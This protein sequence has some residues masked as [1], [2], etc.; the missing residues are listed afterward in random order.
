MHGR[1]YTAS[2]RQPV[3]KRIIFRSVFYAGD[4]PNH[5]RLAMTTLTQSPQ[6]DATDMSALTRAPSFVD[7]RAFGDAELA[8]FRRRP[9]VT[10][11]ADAFV[12]SRAPLNS[13]GKPSTIGALILTGG[14]GRVD[15]MSN[16][17]FIIVLKGLLRI[18]A[19]GVTH[20]LGDSDSAVLPHGAGFDWKAEGEVVAITMRYPDSAATGAAIVPIARDPVLMPSAKPAADILIGPAP[21]CRNFNDYR[22]NDGKFVCGTW[23]STPYHRCGFL[24]G[25]QEIMAIAKGSVTFSDPSGRAQTFT[26]GDVLLA[27]H[28]SQCG[29]ESREDVTKVFAIHRLG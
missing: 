18:E 20:E 5:A 2:L 7:L 24:Y 19:D 14:S 13:S 29:W 23:D 12:T 21:E 27:E 11:S 28:G 6:A 4:H 3:N 22:V 9:P 15:A 26:K 17:E 25:H 8:G 16:D 1:R 10:Q